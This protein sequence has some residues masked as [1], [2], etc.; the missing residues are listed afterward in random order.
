VLNADK[1][2]RVLELRARPAAT[3]TLSAKGSHDPD[4]DGIEPGWFVY[5]EAGTFNGEIALTQSTGENTALLVPA[6]AKRGDT[7]HVILQLRDRGTPSLFAYRRAI[8][9][10]EN[11]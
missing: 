6:N 8:V 4:G 2:K 3:V 11:L 5:R 1:T 7:I 10:V 9:T